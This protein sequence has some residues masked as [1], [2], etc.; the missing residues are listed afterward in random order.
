MEEHAGVHFR[1]G[2]SRRTHHGLANITNREF[3]QDRSFIGA[4][5]SSLTLLI[6]TG[7]TPGIA[8][9]TYLYRGTD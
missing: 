6:D 4:L 1:D 2:A 5:I 9:E 7:Q 3:P 8:A